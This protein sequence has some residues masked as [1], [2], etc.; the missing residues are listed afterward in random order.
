MKRFGKPHNTT[1]VDD[2]RVT[3]LAEVFL[4]ARDEYKRTSREVKNTPQEVVVSLSI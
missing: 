4:S 2:C 3:S 1:K